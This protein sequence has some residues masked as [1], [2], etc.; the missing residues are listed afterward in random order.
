MLISALIVKNAK[1][2]TTLKQSEM[3]WEKRE[4][5]AVFWE[6]Q[7][8]MYASL[9]C[10]ICIIKLP[11]IYSWNKEWLQI[12]KTWDTWNGTFSSHTFCMQ[13]RILRAYFPWVTLPLLLTDSQGAYIFVI[14]LVHFL[15]ADTPR[16]LQQLTHPLETQRI[17]FKL[18]FNKVCFQ[19]SLLFQ[20]QPR[21]VFLARDIQIKALVY[22]KWALLSVQ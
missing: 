6:F 1:L 12:I 8:Y 14:K 20:K 17:K 21:L 22:S 7:G 18:L 2:T 16:H 13:I 11:N 3:G 15:C 10:C 9:L 5:R 19:V 4:F